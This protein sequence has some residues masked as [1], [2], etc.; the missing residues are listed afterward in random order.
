MRWSEK[1]RE[2]RM[3]WQRQEEY[4]ASWSARWYDCVAL[5]TSFTYGR[6]TVSRQNEFVHARMRLGYD[7]PW[8]FTNDNI[9]C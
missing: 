4:R 7:Y 9:D 6:K 1:V 3:E 8:Q 2:F 5:Q